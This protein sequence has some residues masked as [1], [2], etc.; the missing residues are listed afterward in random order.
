MSEYAWVGVIISTFVTTL[1]LGGYMVMIVPYF[2]NAPFLTDLRRHTGIAQAIG[3]VT[4]AFFFVVYYLSARHLTDDNS[5]PLLAFAAFI[6]A[7]PI[8]MLIG[9]ETW[10]HYNPKGMNRV[11]GAQAVMIATGIGLLEIGSALVVFVLIL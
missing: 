2:D 8:S 3:L 10:D 1:A 4:F 9:S 6:I 7:L 5:G 11:P